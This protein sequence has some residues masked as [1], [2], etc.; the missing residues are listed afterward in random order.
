MADKVNL[1]RRVGSLDTA[2][3]FTN[4]SKVIIN[5]NDDTQIVVGDDTGLTLEYT[6]PFGTEAQA[7]EQLESLRGY[8]YQPA[9]AEGAML[10][11]AA[12]IGDGV[13]ANGVYFGVYQRNRKFDRLMRADIAAPHDEEIDHEYKYETPT[14]RKF[15]RQVGDV[16]ATLLIQ[17]GLIQAEVEE[18]TKLGEETQTKFEQTASA[19]SA[20]VSKK[21]PEENTSFAWSLMDDGHYW[22]ANGSSD[23]VLSITKDGLKVKGSGTFSGEIKAT[24][25]NIGGFTISN[26]V[27]KGSSAVISPTELS[28][29]NGNFKVNSSGN[30]YAASGTFNGQTLAGNIASGG[31]NGGKMSG[32][33]IADGSVTKEKLAKAVINA[34]EKCDKLINMDNG[35][36]SIN[37]VKAQHIYCSGGISGTHYGSW[38][39]AN[40]TV[41]NPT[42]KSATFLRNLDGD[43]STIRYL[44]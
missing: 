39:D 14:E 30:L 15:K 9:V 38:E 35:S 3:E 44:G 16:K 24:S 22:Y 10:D 26:G 34:L 29:G 17:A 1:L 41:H 20:R 4:Y 42:W 27:L 5:V 36:I 37:W 28:Y 43:T 13:T 12:E 2:P 6:D 33:H 23:P 18:R 25:G 19:I 40:G 8:Q 11:P 32:S 7:L 31:G 21:S